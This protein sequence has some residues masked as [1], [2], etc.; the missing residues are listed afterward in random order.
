MLLVLLI[1]ILPAIHQSNLRKL[2]FS[3]IINYIIS[4]LGTIVFIF[5]WLA[6]SLVK[7]PI[8]FIILDSGF[9]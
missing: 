6:S 2:T 8:S 9:R 7:I 1:N 5:R 4:H 3:H